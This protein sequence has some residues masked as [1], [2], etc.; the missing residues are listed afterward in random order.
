[1]TIMAASVPVL[2]VFVVEKARQYNSSNARTTSVSRVQPA[3][4]GAVLQAHA[5]ERI[6]TESIR[7]NP[8]G[9]GDRNLSYELSDSMVPSEAPRSQ[10]YCKGSFLEVG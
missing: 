4:S 10:Q 3:R 1:M 2:R 5:F 8:D 6:S 9:K 7:S